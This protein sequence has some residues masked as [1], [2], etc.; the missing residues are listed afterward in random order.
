[1]GGVRDRT[2]QLI[3]AS[4]ASEEEAFDELVRPEGL[5]EAKNRG[6]TDRDDRKQRGSRSTIQ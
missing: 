1:M 5:Q 6:N 2:K 4:R 3:P